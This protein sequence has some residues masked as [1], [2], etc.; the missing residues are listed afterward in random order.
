MLSVYIYIYATCWYWGI[1]L[2]SFSWSVGWRHQFSLMCLQPFLPHNL[3]N[4]VFN[5]DHKFIYSVKSLTGCL[6]CKCVCCSTKWTYHPCAEITAWS[7]GI[8]DQHLSGS[9]PCILT[10]ITDT[11]I[12]VLSL[13]SNIYTCKSF[14]SCLLLQFFFCLSQAV[15]PSLNSIT[16]LLQG[17]INTRTPSL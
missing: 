6:L 11:R 12:S 16:E 8:S 13:K 14:K 15:P 7:T 3:W 9:M 5:Q 17:G 10:L 2:N 1:I 4:A